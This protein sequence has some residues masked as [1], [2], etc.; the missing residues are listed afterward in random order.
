L[1]AGPWPTGEDSWQG[2]TQWPR[3]ALLF[4]QKKMQRK[5]AK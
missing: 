4:G 2:C 5:V 3:A 1:Y